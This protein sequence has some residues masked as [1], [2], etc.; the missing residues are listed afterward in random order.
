MSYSTFRQF[1][2][3]RFGLLKF[4]TKDPKITSTTNNTINKES[5]QRQEFRPK[6]E[7]VM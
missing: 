3:E 7:E 6:S 2:K 5:D 1:I 4:D